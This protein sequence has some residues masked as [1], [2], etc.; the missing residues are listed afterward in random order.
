MDERERTVRAYNA[1]CSSDIAA[2][3]MAFFTPDAVIYDLNH[4][5]VVGREAI[6]AFWAK[7]RARWGGATWATDHVVSDGRTVVAEWTMHGVSTG[8]GDAPF[9]FR[10]ADVFVFA[11]PLIS[12]IRQYWRFDPARLDSGLVGYAYPL[13]ER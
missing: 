7:V 13:V 8:Q 10:G 4:P 6:G 5:P 1:A 2:D 9:A 11:G 3:I 12:E